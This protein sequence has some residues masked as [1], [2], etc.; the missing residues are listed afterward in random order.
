MKDTYFLKDDKG[1]ISVLAYLT[2]DFTNLNEQQ[3]FVL[4]RIEVARGTEKGQGWG[5]KLLTQLCQEA[6]QEGVELLLGVSPDDYGYFRRLVGWYERFGFA[7]AQLYRKQEQV[8]P[9]Y[10]LMLRTPKRST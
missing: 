1:Q 7:A 3:R 2:P 5:T 4:N 9:T 8:T 10:N 6:D